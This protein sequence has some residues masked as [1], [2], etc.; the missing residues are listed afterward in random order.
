MRLLT[1]STI[2]LFLY[3]VVL[4]ALLGDLLPR[5][6]CLIAA[7]SLHKTLLNG[8]FHAPILFYDTTPTGRILSRFSKDI[9]VLD[10]VFPE[11]ICDLIYVFYEVINF[12]KFFTRKY[13]D[14]LTEIDNESR[15]RVFLHFLFASDFNKI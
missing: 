7:T 2:F 13:I 9:D 11:I 4:L 10:S 1:Q 3:F 8:I 12:M 14:E 15:A 5:L 6:G